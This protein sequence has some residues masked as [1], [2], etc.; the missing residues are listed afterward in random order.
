MGVIQ[1]VS[2]RAGVVKDETEL[3]ARAYW[4]DSDR[5]RF[6]RGLPQKLGGWLKRTM[7][8]LFLGICR[9]ILAWQDNSGNARLALGTHL[10]LYTLNG[11]VLTDI[12]P[13]KESGTLANPFSTT[14]ASVTV[15]VADLAHVLFVDDFVNYSGAA[16]V[17]GITID[18][19]Y[20][21]QSIVDVDNYTIDHSTPA[22]ST[23]GPGGGASVAFIYDISIGRE[24]AVAGGGYGVGAYNV[25]TYGTARSGTSL[26]LPP[27]TWALDQW[28]ERLV[29][30]PRDGKIYEWDL[31]T[32]NRAALLTNAPVTN[33]GIVVTDDRHL[34]ALGAAGDKMLVQWCDQD[35]NNNWAA[36]DQTTA[37]SR[38]LTGG[39]EILFGIRTR[40]TTLI[41]TDASVWTMTFIGGLDV[42]GFGAVAGG[43][44]GIISPQAACEAEGI[45]YWMGLNDF[46]LYDGVVRRIAT[47]KDIRRFVFDN[48][49]TTQKAKVICGVNSLFTEIWWF[50]PT[51]TNEITRYVKYNYDDRSWDVGALVRTAMID[52]SVFDLP[53][54]AGT[55]GNLYNHETGVDDDLVAMND[56]ISSG[57]V[58]IGDGNRIYDVL[59]LI[60][61]VKKLTGNLKV[62]LLMRA[63]P[64]DN[65]EQVDVG[66]I[67]A[68]TTR[69]DTDAT[70]RQAR[71]KFETDTLGSDWRM[72]TIR[73]DVVAGG[74][75]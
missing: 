71:L 26:L 46:Y 8:A 34:V 52:L 58:Q 11:T 10:K 13:V 24:D 56:F 50:Y 60:P 20:V 16:A 39:S 21:V 3:A 66:V 5:I 33:V 59:T 53:I 7:D 22:T 70:G 75:V 2:F 14:N 23:A 49:N 36:S 62:T 69:L 41:F 44:S 68:T 15:N 4:T 54:M 67:T 30:C 45:V 6:V 37:G 74:Q 19:D 63:Y 65:E 64:Q 42:F 1:E 61:D 47:S 48:L 43:S 38:L 57:P 32:S 40:G 35:D 9:G 55:D 29:A 17:G 28:S 12:T 31:N 73:L 51:T 72:G 27:R 18:G 25:G